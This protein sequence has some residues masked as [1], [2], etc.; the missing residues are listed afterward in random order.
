MKKPGWEED[1]GAGAGGPLRVVGAGPKRE[2]GGGT[3]LYDT[4][5]YGGGFST[6]AW[7]AAFA[8]GTGI[9]GYPLVVVQV[10]GEDE[11]MGAVGR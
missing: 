8:A 9:V 10:T 7:A 11:E 4:L 1:G 2:G 5:P 6:V 3:A